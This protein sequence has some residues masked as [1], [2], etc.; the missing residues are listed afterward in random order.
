L[1]IVDSSFSCT[2]VSH[3]KQKLGGDA[4][5]TRHLTRDGHGGIPKNTKP[6]FTLT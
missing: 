4:A 3:C 5:T 1:K 6:S 2:R